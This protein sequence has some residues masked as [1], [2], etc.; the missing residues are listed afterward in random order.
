MKN[1]GAPTVD[2]QKY[3]DSLRR[4]WRRP[5]LR[6]HPIHAIARRISWRLHWKR[7]PGVPIVLNNWRRDLKIALP[8]TGNAALLF[9]RTHSDPTM[10]WLLQALLSPGMTF[11]DVGAHIG[12][13]TLVGG[14]MVGE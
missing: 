14:Q 3:V 2:I 6:H 12:E 5:E 8:H 11:L 7:S 1:A 10:A 9:Y 13:F 4:G